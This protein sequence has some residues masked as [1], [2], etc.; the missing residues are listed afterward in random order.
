MWGRVPKLNMPEINVEALVDEPLSHWDE[1][2]RKHLPESDDLSLVVLKSH[3]VLEQQL[4]ALIAH[5]CPRPDYLIGA[6]L[7]FSQKLDLVHAFVPMPIRDGIWDALRLLNT[8]RNDLAHNLEPPKLAKRLASAKTLATRLARRAPGPKP[9]LTKDAEVIKYLAG[10]AHGYL[11]AVD[12]I[13][14]LMKAER[15]Y[16]RTQRS[17]LAR[18]RRAVTGAYRITRRL[19]SRL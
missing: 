5:Y 13:V 19:G 15:K 6:R 17:W 1:L 3:L 14:A 18:F 12:A 7:R 11:A 2:T 8:I 4:T 10:V 9:A 16:N